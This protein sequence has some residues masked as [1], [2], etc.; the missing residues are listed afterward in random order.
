MNH[1]HQEDKDSHLDIQVNE[2]MSDSCLASSV[3][4]DLCPPEKQTGASRVHIYLW[5]Y[6]H[7]DRTRG[8]QSTA[9]FELFRSRFTV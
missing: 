3:S 4:K 7:N 5:F 9:D 1:S 6:F 8:C 2:M